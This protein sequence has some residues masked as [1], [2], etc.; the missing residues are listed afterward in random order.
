MPYGKFVA[1]LRSV[2]ASVVSD[3]V[4]HS[5]AS[6]SLRRFLPTVADVIQLPIELRH[7]I[8]D[9][10]D[11][12]VVTNKFGREPMPVHY[13]QSRLD[14]VCHAKRLCLAALHSAF[15]G[16]GEAS[17]EMEDLRQYTTSLERLSMLAM[18]N[19]FGKVGVSP[20]AT[21]LKKLPDVPSSI[22]APGSSSSS[23]SGSS[24]SG[25]DSAS[26]ESF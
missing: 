5:L 4:V 14:S 3:S 18:S 24:D 16:R 20:N 15:S 25:S 2:M 26:A 1:L 12:P 7:H 10:K 13:S 11:V 21:S 17:V 22:S 6:Y 19:D 8:G 23:S 9:W